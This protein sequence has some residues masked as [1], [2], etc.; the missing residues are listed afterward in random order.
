MEIIT[1]ASG[2]RV[3]TA[4]TL[5]DQAWLLMTEVR[6]N[7]LIFKNEGGN[8]VVLKPSKYKFLPSDLQAG[9]RA[10]KKT[11]VGDPAVMWGTEA[12]SLLET[13]VCSPS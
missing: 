1:L 11:G 4:T 3:I 12:Q 6:E 10:A 2:V 5:D 13:T 9:V 8:L 7:D